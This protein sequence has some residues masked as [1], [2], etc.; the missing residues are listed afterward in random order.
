VLLERGPRTGGL[1]ASFDV[2]GV[3]VD[4]GSHRLH[5]ATAPH[6]LEELRGL[7]GADLQC[8]PRHGRLRVG[9]GWVAFP[10]SPVGLART[11]PPRVTAQLVRDLATAPARRPR[12]DTFAEVVRAGVGPALGEHIY[13]PYARKLWGT[14]PEDLSGEQARRRISAP[15]PLAIA[16]RALRRGR[17]A[18]FFY[19]RRGFGQI[20][21][22]LS[23]AA[24][25]AGAE[26][27]TSAEVTSV[28]ASGRIH[29]AGGDTLDAGVVLSTI[30]LAALARLVRPTAPAA[31]IDAT[32]ELRSRA[33]VLVYLVLDHAPWT[34]FD[35]HYLPGL[36]LLAARVSEPR[37]YRDGDDPPDRTVLC[38]EVPCWPDDDTWHAPAAALASRVVD[39]LGRLGLPPARPVE[40]EVRRVPSVYPV[41]RVGFEPGLAAIE[42][43]LDAHPALVTLGRQG[44]FAHDN[45]HH[46]LEMA[47]SA[48]DCVRDGT[49]DRTGWS[50][51]RARFRTHVVE[52]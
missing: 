39:D 4:H 46:T 27:R 31:V 5:P 30:P 24:V 37:N 9:G 40:F 3:R 25:D 15:S 18:H 10:P 13:Y 49:F 43:W 38:A 14:A 48:V 29:V 7:L 8:R 47:W 2:G 21:E 33:M 22:A 28:D 6:I 1:A 16:R 11:L 52:D 50:E 41:Y 36:D 12:A 42:Q 26:V 35:A 51:A 44:L 32:N 19:P 20:A 34:A 45:T 23:A 17:H